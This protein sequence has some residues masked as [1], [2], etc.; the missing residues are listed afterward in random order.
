MNA[1]PQLVGELQFLG[2][3]PIL[4]EIDQFCSDAFHAPFETRR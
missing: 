1:V 4:L 2:K 3:N